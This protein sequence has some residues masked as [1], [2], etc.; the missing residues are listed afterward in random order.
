MGWHAD[1]EKELISDK[2]LM[3]HIKR[4]GFSWGEITSALNSF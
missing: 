2:K 1:N 4:K 3:S